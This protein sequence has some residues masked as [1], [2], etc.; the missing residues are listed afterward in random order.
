MVLNYVIPA[1]IVLEL[2]MIGIQSAVYNHSFK[3]M[4]YAPIDQIYLGFAVPFF[5]GC[6]AWLMYFKEADRTFSTWSRSIRAAQGVT[7]FIIG[8][9]MIWSAEIVEE[10]CRML[11]L[12]FQGSCQLRELKITAGTL[13]LVDGVFYFLKPCQY[14]L[15]PLGVMMPQYQQPSMPVAVTVNVASNQG[16]APSPWNAPPAPPGPSPWHAAPPPPPPA[17]APWY[18]QPPPPPPYSQMGPYQ[19]PKY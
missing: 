18:P 19:Y 1:N 11:K 15:R 13:A 8:V 6:F 17:P 12:L 5:V 3:R 10:Q 9:I 4:T 2:I 16:P 14:V 7:L